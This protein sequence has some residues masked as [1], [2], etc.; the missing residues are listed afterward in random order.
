MVGE[1]GGDSRRANRW[2]K[3]GHADATADGY[4]ANGRGVRANVMVLTVEGFEIVRWCSN[5]YS[6]K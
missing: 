2:P 4:E 3:G 6:E 5:R 1:M